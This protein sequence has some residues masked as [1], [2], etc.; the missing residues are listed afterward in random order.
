MST[1]TSTD[2]PSLDS[3]RT[4]YATSTSRRRWS[5][6]PSI[7]SSQ[8]ESSISTKTGSLKLKEMREAEETR[9]KA[10]VGL[11]ALSEETGIP[12]EH[13]HRSL[14]SDREIDADADLAASFA[15]RYPEAH[16]LRIGGPKGYG[17][18][19]REPAFWLCTDCGESAWLLDPTDAEVAEG[20]MAIEVTPTETHLH[21][22]VRVP[23]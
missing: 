1:K 5:G 11:S 6:R 13:P 9:C 4:R 17:T 21:A 12:V 18:P 23:A 14:V 19:G 20:L 15:I 7:D 8:A 16:A 3:C 10:T 22:A 2:Y